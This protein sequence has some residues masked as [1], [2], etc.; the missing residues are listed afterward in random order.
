MVCGLAS[1]LKVGRLAAYGTS[2]ARTAELLQGWVRYEKAR[3]LSP[4]QRAELHV[5]NLAGENFDSLIDALPAPS[6]PKPAA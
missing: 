3:K 1:D 2:P 6:T 5:R 4:R